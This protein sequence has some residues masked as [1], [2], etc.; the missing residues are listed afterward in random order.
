MASSLLQVS[1]VFKHSFRLSTI[2]MNGGFFNT[3]S[4][5]AQYLHNAYR[6]VGEY[7]RR[8]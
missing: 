1:P 5:M 6:L 7:V 2:A 8:G 4:M 3:Q